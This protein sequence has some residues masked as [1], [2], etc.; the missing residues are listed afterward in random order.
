MSNQKQKVVYV[1]RE[2]PVH[3]GFDIV[4]V[5]LAVIVASIAGAVVGGAV[6]NKWSRDRHALA[7]QTL[8]EF[9]SAADDDSVANRTRALDVWL[10]VDNPTSTNYYALTKQRDG[11][12]ELDFKAAT[13]V[14][15]YCGTTPEDVRGGTWWAARQSPDD[16]WYYRPYQDIANL[17]NGVWQSGYFPAENKPR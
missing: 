5:T 16:W 13:K 7:H 14:T 8:R 6:I 4:P 9:I 12:L 2:V 3:T 1:D 17:T 15:A 11:I 10:R